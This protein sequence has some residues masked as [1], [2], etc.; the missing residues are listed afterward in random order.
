MTQREILRTIRCEI[1]SGSGRDSRVTGNIL[2]RSAIAKFRR[3]F[4]RRG[5]EWASAFDA[6]KTEALDIL[7]AY[8]VE[9]KAVIEALD[10]FVFAFDDRIKGFDA[11]CAAQKKNIGL[12][13]RAGEAAEVI[14]KLYIE[15]EQAYGFILHLDLM[16]GE[17]LMARCF[18]STDKLWA[19]R[20]RAIEA[21]LSVSDDVENRTFNLI[22][23]AIMMLDEAELCAES[24]ADDGLRALLKPE[25]KSEA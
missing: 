19:A 22:E 13:K 10:A 23:S 11:L 7:R 20:R 6:A 5:A 12:A 3:G 8:D 18:E 4:D 14:A 17:E 25:S 1:I 16:F 21:A 9:K 15:L 2:A 24:L